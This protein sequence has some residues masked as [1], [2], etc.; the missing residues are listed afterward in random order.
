MIEYIIAGLIFGGLAVSKGKDVKQSIKENGV[1]QTID[2]EA[3][4][5]NKAVKK[6]HDEF[7]KKV[8]K[9]VEARKK[10]MTK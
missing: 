6:Q 10:E 4:N 8:N 3:N 9:Q 1:S 5:L 7:E 2:K